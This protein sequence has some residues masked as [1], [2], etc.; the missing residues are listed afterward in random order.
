MSKSGRFIL[1]TVLGGILGMLVALA[2][3]QIIWWLG[4]LVGSLIAGF[5]YALPDIIRHAPTA[6][7]TAWHSLIYTPKIIRATGRIIAGIVLAIFF[8]LGIRSKMTTGQ[9]LMA[10]IVWVSLA[11]YGTLVYFTIRRPIENG[12]LGA[13]TTL[14]ILGAVTYMA[15]A[16]ILALRATYGPFDR[17]K[18]LTD[19]E[20]VAI[21]KKTLFYVSPFGV[22]FMA[23]W[24]IVGMIKIMACIVYESSKLI[25]KFARTLYILVHTKE[26]T[27]VGIDTALGITAT[28]QLFVR[29]GE[30]ILGIGPTLV[31][32]GFISVL[33]GY[34]IDYQIISRRI[35]HLNGQKI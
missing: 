16:A 24:G 32:S 13:E 5:T 11:S 18:Y 30:P 9:R 28:Y 23:S 4:P 10:A 17:K 15:F 22:I 35:L 21:R 19:S 2:V 33:L 20:K 26:L 3:P 27:L 7:R 31:M 8:L 25:V 6:G 14:F 34:F 12:P 29:Q 1:A